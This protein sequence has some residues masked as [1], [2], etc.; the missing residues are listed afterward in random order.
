MVTSLIP[1]ANEPESASAARPENWVLHATVLW[2]FRRL[3]VRVASIAL[4]FSVAVAFTMPK[5]YESVARIM[6]PD[7]PGSGAMMLAA[8]ASR[9]GGLGGLSSMAGS[10][11]SGRSSTALYVDL[12]HSGTV[13]GHLIDRFQLQKVYRVRYQVD[14]AKRLAR[15]TTISDDKKSGVITI[16]VQDTN[17]VRARDLAQGYLDELNKLV[18]QTSTSSAHQ[19]RIFI[20]KRLHTVEADLVHPALLS[21]RDRHRERLPVV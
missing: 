11:F 15:R 2:R 17:P 20:E 7:Q 8:L 19:E 16:K 4:L 14:T 10:L 21:V 9:A 3:L 1:P 5:R 18:M 12:L 6:S 13:S